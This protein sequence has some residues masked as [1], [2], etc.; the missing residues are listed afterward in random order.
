MYVLK[1][2]EHWVIITVLNAILWLRMCSSKGPIWAY[3]VYIFCW[4]LLGICVHNKNRHT[5][6]SFENM[7]ILWS[8]EGFYFTIFCTHLFQSATVITSFIY[9]VILCGNVKSFLNSLCPFFSL[10]CGHL[11]I[12]YF[13]RRVLSRLITSFQGCPGPALADNT[14]NKTAQDN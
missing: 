12:L 5:S 4:W 8:F 7:L 6:M 3:E 13:S 11:F 2:E 14:I 9:R 10:P 1:N